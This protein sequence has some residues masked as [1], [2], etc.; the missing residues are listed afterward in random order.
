M[1]KHYG[2][3]LGFC[4]DNL[5]PDNRNRITLRVPQI[6]GE[7]AVTTW[8]LPCSPVTSNANHPDHQEHTAAQIAVLLTTTATTAADPQGGSVTI[9]ALT[10][11]AKAGAATLKHP[12]KT[13]A[14]T[15]ERWND[16]QET[17]TTAEHTPHRIVPKINQP[18]WVMFVAG[19]A[20]FPVWMG[21]LND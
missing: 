21:V 9:P 8:A 12:K 20:N 4:V 3:Y 14:D 19:D 7:T 15:D 18:V 13:A 16:S 11:V 17:N 5:D 2:L 10:V 1:E 6:F